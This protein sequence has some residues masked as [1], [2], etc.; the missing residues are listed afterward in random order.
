MM[1][2]TTL[3]KFLEKAPL[4]LPKKRNYFIETSWSHYEHVH[5][6]KDLQLTRQI[7]AEK[8]PDYL[9]SFDK[10][11]QK[12]AV[13]MFNMLIARADIFDKY[14]QWLFQ[15]LPEVEKGLISVIIRLMK[16]VFMAFLVNI[17]GCLG[18]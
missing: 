2:S 1:T 10:M 12:K 15:I 6:I 11:L 4:I 7:I 5:H 17:I 9:P 13:H 14:T 16:S 18:R 3:Q 8:F